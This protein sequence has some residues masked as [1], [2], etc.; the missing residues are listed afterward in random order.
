[1][2][3]LSAEDELM[4][5]EFQLAIQRKANGGVID[6]D[7]KFNHKFDFQIHRFEDVLANSNRTIP[8]NRWSYHRIGLLTQGE[9][10]FS[11]G[12][13][14]FKAQK[15]TLLVIP[16]R[17]ITSSKHW[18][19]DTKGY[20]LLFNLDFFLQNNFPHQY[21][22]NKKILTASIRPYIDLTDLQA[23]EMTEI[24]EDILVEKYSTNNHKSE[25]IA[26]KVIELLINSE[27]LF[28]K[29]QNLQT[30]TPFAEV[31]K[32]FIDLLDSY[33]LKEHSVTFY[34]TRLSLHP[35]YLNLQ[36]KR[37]TGMNAKEIIQNRLLLETKFL[38]HSTKLSIKEISNQVGFSDPNY[39]AAFFKR[40]EHMSPANYRT[41]YV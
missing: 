5:N 28:E 11:T 4:L 34:A 1:V 23:K 33:Y 30:L 8:P 31:I 32:R 26:L 38:L 17:V 16:S 37:H 18:T 36:I 35:N 7:S 25:L 10:Y 22:E 15:N 40:L 13:Y 2:N 14:K 29:E 27:R 24:F 39:F 19:M 12:I 6:L 9:G 3:H 20:I 21:I 41:A